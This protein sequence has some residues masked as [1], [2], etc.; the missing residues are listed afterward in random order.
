[1][2]ASFID[3][4]P[5]FLS[6]SLRYIDDNYQLRSKNFPA[7]F[8]IIPMYLLMLRYKATV[9]APLLLLLS[10]FTLLVAKSK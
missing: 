2:T 4:H 9:P 10:H 1:M 7:G 8:V 6:E 5:F 3:N